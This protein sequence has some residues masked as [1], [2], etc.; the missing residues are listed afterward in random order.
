MF[1]DLKILPTLHEIVFQYWYSHLSEIFLWASSHHKVGSA[2]PLLCQQASLTCL[3]LCSFNFPGLPTQ[4]SLGVPASFTTNHM[5]SCR[6]NGPNKMGCY[7]LLD[8]V[9]LSLLKFGAQKWNWFV[10]S[11][12]GGAW[13]LSN[14]SILPWELLIQR[15][16]QSFNHM[17]VLMECYVSL[18]AT[19]DT[20]PISEYQVRTSILRKLPIVYHWVLL[21][22]SVRAS[23]LFFFPFRLG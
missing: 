20:R 4:E 6:V 22:Y 16:T 8:I 3:D 23:W 5:S 19:P 11:Q 14:F 18:L 10:F 12:C 2:F 1:K 21:R 17:P 9:P 13:F 15:Y 7:F